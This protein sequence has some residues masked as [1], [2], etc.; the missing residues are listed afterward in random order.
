V[1]VPPQRRCREST[2]HMKAILQR[3]DTGTM[4][5]RQ[6]R[7]RTVVAPERLRRRSVISQG[8]RPCAAV[9]SGT[10]ALHHAESRQARPSPPEHLAC[11][12]QLRGLPLLLLRLA[13]RHLALQRV[14]LTGARQ[15]A[16]RT[17]AAVVVARSLPNA[18]REMLGRCRPAALPMQRWRVRT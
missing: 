17:T 1:C 12:S 15:Q 8:G 5:S 13:Q 14:D 2:K 18:M 3:P 4:V 7:R 16:T 9:L 6:R 11:S 10:T